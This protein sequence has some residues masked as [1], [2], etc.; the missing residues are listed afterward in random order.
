[1]DIVNKKKENISN[2]LFS[3]YFKYSSPKNMMSKLS[4]S[5]DEINKNRV[6]SINEKLTKIKNIVKTVP[7]DKVFKTEENAKIIDIVERIELN[8]ENKLG[9]GLKLLAPTQMLSRLAIS[10]A[11]LKAVNNDEKL[12]SKI[13]QILYSLYRSK[14]VQSNS[15]KV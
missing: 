8:S 9:L 5:R 2:E 11:Q 4:N 3:H 14:N 13:R 15:A 12:K 6:N 7:K 10:L 1:M